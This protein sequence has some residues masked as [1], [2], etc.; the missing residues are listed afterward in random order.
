MTQ[1]LPDP[2]FASQVV[3]V[4]GA[5]K[6]L[7]RSYALH[8]AAHGAHVIVNNRWTN[9]SEPSSA[10]SV[11]NEIRAAGGSAIACFD[12]AEDPASGPAM[13]DLA[14]RTFG[15]LDGLIANAGVPEARSFKKHTVESFRAI[16]DINFMGT[17]HIVHAAWPVMMD[18]KYGRIV[19]STSGAG[20]HANAGMAAYSSSKAALIGL[21]KAL[22]L[23][24]AKN[25]VMANAIAPYAATPMTSEYMTDPT[26]T[27]LLSP[28]K[29]APV[30]G[31]LVSR[32]CTFS[33][34][35]VIAAGGLVRA[36]FAEESAAQRLAMGTAQAIKA[37]VSD[38]ARYR[39]VDANAA[40]AD[41]V[42]HCPTPEGRSPA[43]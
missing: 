28:D 12:P 43:K 17:L 9:R 15:R 33:G 19:V 40:F 39:F 27:D 13:V 21:I 8:L 30:A 7:G 4:T 25:N 16:F 29:V 41:L 11:V 5:G 18:Q 20:L 31:W 14:I 35:V 32:Q 38:D 37:A 1:K 24:G 10:Q 26:M 36:A 23:E 22:A 34:Q 3:I 6:G 42:S 2:N